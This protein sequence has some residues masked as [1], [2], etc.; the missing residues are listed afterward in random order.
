MGLTDNYTDIGMSPKQTN[1][2]QAVLSD[3]L[4]GLRSDNIFTLQEVRADSE[5]NNAKA[6]DINIY[7]NKDDQ[8]PIVIIEVTTSDEEDI[9]ISKVEELMDNYKTIKEG[10]IY[11]Y[12]TD[13]WFS[14]MD[15]SES[16][17][18]DFSPKLDVYFRDY[19]S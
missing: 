2:H 14:L 6:P 7:E 9:I 8:F 11:N 1:E 5:N 3:L 13:E 10:F 19:L 18:A 4:F 12:E 15:K 17:P 16:Y